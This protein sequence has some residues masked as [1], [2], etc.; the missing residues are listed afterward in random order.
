MKR[1]NHAPKVIR[2]YGG[3]IVIYRYPDGRGWGYE[4]RAAR[5]HR[6]PRKVVFRGKEF[7]IGDTSSYG[8]GSADKFAEARRW[9]VNNVKMDRRP[10]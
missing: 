3:K 9:A 6:P 7:L 8:V 1:I 10:P 4:F 5:K 2:A